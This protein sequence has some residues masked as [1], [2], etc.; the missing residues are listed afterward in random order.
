MVPKYKTTIPITEEELKDLTIVKANLEQILQK[1]LTIRA[2]FS[3]IL[4]YM[5]EK[6]NLEEFKKEILSI[7]EI[8]NKEISRVETITTEKE[9][10]QEGIRQT[11]IAEKESK[12]MKKERQEK[13]GFLSS[14]FKRK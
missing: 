10:V 12:E 8:E 6:A 3:L 7:S 9:N 1:P 2:T 11:E 14:I 4:R 13:G 5:K